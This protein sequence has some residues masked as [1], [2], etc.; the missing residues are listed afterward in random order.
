MKERFGRVQKSWL[1]GFCC[2][3][4]WFQQFWGT[5]FPCPWVSDATSVTFKP[6]PLLCEPSFS[7][8][9]LMFFFFWLLLMFIFLTAL[10]G[11]LRC[12]FLLTCERCSRFQDF[13]F[14]PIVLVF[15]RHMFKVFI[16][17]LSFGYFSQPHQKRTLTVLKIILLFWEL[18]PWASY[19]K[20]SHSSLPQ[21]PPVSPTPK[22]HDLF[23]YFFVIFPRQ[24]FQARI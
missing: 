5:R 20:L 6:G 10:L 1:I 4:V 18:W 19:L 7:F 13:F 23:F 16:E 12:V 9:Y 21:T 15:Q 3:F 8:P 14:N 22:I 2:F 11:A 17:M 24:D